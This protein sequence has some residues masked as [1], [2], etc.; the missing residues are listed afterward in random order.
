MAEAM[1]SFRHDAQVAQVLEWLKQVAQNKG[2]LSVGR[3]GVMLPIRLFKKYREGAAATVSVFNRRGERLGTVDLGQMPQAGQETLSEELTRLVRDVLLAW[4]GPALRLVYLTDAGFHPT[5]SFERVL[6]RIPDPR[7]PGTYFA[8]E[9]VVDYYHACQ[10]ITQLAEALF[11]RGRA[12]HAWAAKMRR[13]LKHK[14]RAF[15]GCFAAPVRCAAFADW[16]AR[17]GATIEP[18]LI[19]AITPVRWTTGLTGIGGRRSAAA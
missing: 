13:W 3:D 15:I 12:A 14:P 18:M 11:G 10:Y 16:W 6:S 17:K 9:W 1:S 4:D 8:W 5:E 7:H 2:T 19:C